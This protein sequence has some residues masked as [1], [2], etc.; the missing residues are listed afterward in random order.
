MY[1]YA[2]F[3][4][5]YKWNRNEADSVSTI[6]IKVLVKCNSKLHLYVLGILKP[7][8][9]IKNLK[10]V[11]FESVILLLGIEPKEVWYKFAYPTPD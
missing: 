10:D 3:R 4:F 8:V 2:Y 1:K 9:K 5:C 7:P 11:C 6:K